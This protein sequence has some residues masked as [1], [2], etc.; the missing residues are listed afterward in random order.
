MT[1]IGRRSATLPEVKDRPRVLLLWP[2]GLFQR[3]AN[4]GVPQILS[5]AGAV[6]GAGGEVTVVDL[7]CERALGPVNL[8]ALAAGYDLIGVSCYSSYDYLKVMAIGEH[9]RAAAPRAWIVVGG[10]HPS[11]RPGDFTGADSPYDYVVVG[12]G[13]GSLA[14]LTEALSSGKKPLTR[15]LGPTSS[16]G[17]GDYDW[18]LLARYLPVARKVASQAEI[19]LSRGCPY[20]CAFCMERAKRD[21][22]WR[23]REPEHA[24]EQ[25]HQLDSFLDL[26]GWTVFVA[27]ALFGMKQGWR[28]ALLEGLARRPLRA[29]K[30]W[31]LIRID[32]VDREDLELMARAN[33]APGFG[34]ESGDPEQVRRVRKTGKLG[35][36]LE[37]LL[38]IGGWARELGVPFGANVILGHPGETE[39]SIRTTAAYLRRLF[40]GDSRGTTG[41]LSVDP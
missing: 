21:T 23:A 34:L 20:D 17:P 18:S 35:D 5:L 24:L 29:D 36:Y 41:F 40:L 31:L 16:P 27:D 30:V 38:Q 1:T 14:R 7:D 39:A 6:R 22:S 10:Y 13:E 2:G 26:R 9:L 32:L 4:F 12:D 25:L 3:G 15:V 37:R 33:V 8:R 28:R 19:Y 11:A